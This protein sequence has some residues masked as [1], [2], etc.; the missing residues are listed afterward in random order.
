MKCVYSVATYLE[1]IEHTGQRGVREDNIL[2]VQILMILRSPVLIREISTLSLFICFVLDMNT[3]H[4][5]N[6]TKQYYLYGF[7]NA[8][9]EW[10]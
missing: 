10:V 8:L 4:D 7:F 3:P 9:K 6:N 1:F 2:R 5:S